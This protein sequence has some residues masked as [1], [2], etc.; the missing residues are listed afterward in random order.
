MPCKRLRKELDELLLLDEEGRFCRERTEPPRDELVRPDVLE[1]PDRLVDPDLGE[2][3][4]RGEL[5]PV[6]K[7]CIVA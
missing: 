1:V 4:G 7:S 5:E 6:I 3:L 2:E